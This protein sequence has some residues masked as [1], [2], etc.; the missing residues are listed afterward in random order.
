MPVVACIDLR[1]ESRN[2]GL[3]PWH[4]IIP[5]W[6]NSCGKGE[7]T[8]T[9]PNEW[10]GSDYIR[11]SCPLQLRRGLWPWEL[12]SVLQP[13]SWKQ[14]CPW[15]KGALF[16]NGNGEFQMGTD[17]A[18][19]SAQTHEKSEMIKVLVKIKVSTGT[20]AVWP[21]FFQ[22]FLLVLLWCCPASP[23][24]VILD[25]NKQLLS[26]TRKELKRER[27]PAFAVYRPVCPPPAQSHVFWAGWHGQQVR[28]H[29]GGPG[30]T[31]RCGIAQQKKFTIKI[32]TPSPR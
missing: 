12:F 21:H 11:S 32:A 26:L 27:C 9:P 31:W 20:R 23:H 3:H 16:Y 8:D 13:Y 14:S 22:A 6:Y 2:D 28:P 15:N 19:Y 18:Q 30:P 5:A 7:N 17:S 10:H 29:T 4:R 25:I 1:H 24:N